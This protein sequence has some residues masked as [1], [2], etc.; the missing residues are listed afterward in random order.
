MCITW[1]IIGITQQLITKDWSFTSPF[2]FLFSVLT[3]NYFSVRRLSLSGLWHAIS[4]VYKQIV[5]KMCL[6]SI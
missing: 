1:H 2:L 3:S 6:D 4:W 5:F